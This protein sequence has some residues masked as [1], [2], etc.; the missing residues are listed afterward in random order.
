VIYWATPDRPEG[1]V[2]F[3][4]RVSVGRVAGAVTNAL[5]GISPFVVTRSW[6]TTGTGKLIVAG[7]VGLPA[8]A[9]FL[10]EKLNETYSQQMARL[11]HAGGG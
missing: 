8:I 5:G 9:T 3:L 10:P 7:F 11:E 4:K 1:T 2:Q 6:D